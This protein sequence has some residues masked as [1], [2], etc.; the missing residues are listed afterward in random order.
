MQV[1]KGVVP[2]SRSAN[3]V[4]DLRIKMLMPVYKEHSSAAS[5]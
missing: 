3:R 5:L 2:K 4:F 1:L